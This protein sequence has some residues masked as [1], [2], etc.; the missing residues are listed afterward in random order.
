MRRPPEQKRSAPDK[1][2]A[3]MVQA[4]RSAFAVDMTSVTHVV[5]DQVGAHFDVLEQS[6]FA[7][8]GAIAIEALKL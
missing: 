5:C 1:V 8:F 7:R 6:G 4:R 2:A 3:N